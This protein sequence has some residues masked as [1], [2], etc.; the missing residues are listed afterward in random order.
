MSKILFIGYNPPFL[1][2]DRKVEA[3]HY[4]NWQFLQPLLD[5]QH[6][7][8]FCADNQGPPPALPE[9]WQGQVTYHSVPFRRKIGWV[10]QL[11]QIHDSFR[12]DCILA[13]DKDNCL[14][15]TRLRTDK[16]I[17]MD[18][19]GDYLT[20][21]QVARYRKGSDRGIPTAIGLYKKILQKGDVFSGCGTPQQHMMVGE[22][23]M[24]GRLNSR[25]F[26]Y[27]FARVVLPGSP[28]AD[29]ATTK[30][31]PRTFLA[32]KGVP[33]DAFVVLWCGGYNTWTDVATLF[34]GLEKAMAQN[35]RIHYVSVGAN[36]Y[37]APNNVYSRFQEMIAQSTYKD[38]FHLMGWRPWVEVAKYYRE[39]DVGFNIDA[40]HY[41]TIYGTR[42]RLVE[43]LAA[44]LPVITS[45]GCEL[46]ELLDK[47]GAGLTF[48]SG[49]AQEMGDRIL[50]IAQDSALHE[51]MIEKALS[52][53][54]NELSFAA[55]TAEVR[56]WAA[57]PKKAPDNTVSGSQEKLQQ[58]GYQLR[59]TI[60]Q[61]LWSIFGME[62][63]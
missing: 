3:A 20:I 33:K 29:A 27:E 59:A 11:Q 52:Y 41:E 21:M 51:S 16:P 1:E 46:A 40:L 48:A 49:D 28:P 44:G 26:G 37:E 14:S 55:T 8:C 22:L 35:E 47:N 30:S 12:P 57:N 36:T 18:I 10:S 60:R 58:A 63:S 50:T 5:D 19:Y 9:T 61:L 34:A 17:W 45:L 39:S 24:A 23:A 56:K 25:T 6:T 54:R 15:V 43:M 13:V 2:G 62:R 32:G 42:T 31:T 7:I 4:R 53:A 38:R